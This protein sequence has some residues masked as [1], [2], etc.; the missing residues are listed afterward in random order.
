MHPEHHVWLGPIDGLGHR[1]QGKVGLKQ[2]TKH[3][4][5]F[6]VVLRIFYLPAHPS[7]YFNL[8]ALCY[9]QNNN[10]FL[11]NATRPNNTYKK[12]LKLKYN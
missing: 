1:D 4:T 11:P 10:F 8:E 7:A 3:V 12:K 5:S 2:V 9:F 6:N